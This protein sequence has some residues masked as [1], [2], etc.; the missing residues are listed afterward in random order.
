[1]II[2]IVI[3]VLA[4]ATNWWA[5]AR[6]DALLEHIAKPAATLCAIAVATLSGGDAAV[7]SL[8]VAAL[9]L[10]LVGDVLLLPRVNQFVPGLAAFAVAHVVF[11][12]MFVTLGMR[13]W[14]L[15]GVALSACALLIGTVA[16]P[17]IRH[18]AA[19]G[20]GV[21]V[22]V[23]L[24]V[25]SAM[26]LLGWATGNI[27]AAVGS[28]LFVLSDTL[29]GWRRFVRRDGGDRRLAVSVMVTY[30]AAIFVLASSP[31]L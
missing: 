14:W 13:R 12:A 2:A 4:A 6:G 25:I 17:I 5:V 31:G 19:A 26:A 20:L 8:A 24:G 3:G 27:A 23:Y 18:A 30:H 21:P 22:R 28:A 11:G 10:C 7:V 1:V 15:A 9:A 29:L 16:V